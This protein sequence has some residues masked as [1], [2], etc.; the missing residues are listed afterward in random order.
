MS[1]VKRNNDS[2]MT[3]FLK[4]LIT[5]LRHQLIN[6]TYLFSHLQECH[7]TSKRNPTRP[8]NK[9]K[10]HS[11]VKDDLMRVFKCLRFCYLKKY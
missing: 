6:P 1:I 9:K 5:S 3:P 4:K 10:N 8:L 7:L 11:T 2:E